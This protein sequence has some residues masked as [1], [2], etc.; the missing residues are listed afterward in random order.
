MSRKEVLRKGYLDLLLAG[1]DDTDVAKVITGMRRCGKSTLMRQYMDQLRNLGVLDD[2][3]IYANFESRDMECITDNKELNK[4]LAERIGKERTYVFLD[5]IQRVDGWEKTINS[6]QVDYDADVYIT[7]SNAYLLSSELSTYIAGRYIEIRMLP[8]SFSEYL[9]LNPGQRDD[10]FMQYLRFGGMPSLD[11]DRDE[12]YLQDILNGISSTVVHKDVISRL[13]IRDVAT[14]E[15]VMKFLMSNIGNITSR[16]VIAET[17]HTSNITVGKYLKGMKD[18]FLIHEALRY[19]I[20]GKKFLRTHQKYY[21]VDTGIRNA[22]LEDM[23][24]SD[25]GRL[26][27]NA[28]YL[29]LVRRGYTV[30][31][32]SYYDKEIDFIAIRNGRAEYYQVATSVLSD[33]VAEREVRILLSVPDNYRKIVLTLDTF[34]RD[35]GSG[36][37]HRNAAEWMLTGPDRDCFGSSR[38]A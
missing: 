19:D 35:L 17:I 15:G 3:I 11:M 13:S 28:V 30:R 7:G 24:G 20:R 38:T 18:A 10:M 14:F 34:V 31:I 37:E 16:N 1:K 32:G 25:V 26:L 29:E 27:E 33:Q 23:G 22:V 6:I 8:L 5:E 36:I 2:H 12:S 4:W 21:S 9:E